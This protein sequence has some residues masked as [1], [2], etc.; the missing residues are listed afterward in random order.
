M[1]Q[2]KTESAKSQPVA[3]D[4]AREPTILLL[5]HKMSINCIQYMQEEEED[6]YIELNYYYYYNDNDHLK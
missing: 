3:R 1:T 4:F 5:A 2:T 6:E